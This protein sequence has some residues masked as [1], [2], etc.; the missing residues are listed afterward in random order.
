[1]SIIKNLKKKYGRFVID[2]P[3][4]NLPDQGITSLIGP[5]GAG[6]TSFL[7]ILS[8][9][10][11]CPSLQWIFNKQDLAQLPI[12]ERKIGFVFQ[13]LELFPHMTAYENIQFAGEISTKN[14]KKDLEFLTRSL[15]LT[16]I[17]H[18]KASELSRGEAQ[19]V[20]LSRALV[21]R[22]RILFLDEPF[23][24]LD[25]EN[26]KKASSIVQQMVEHYKIPALLI[27][28]HSEDIKNLSQKVIKIQNGKIQ[29]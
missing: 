17:I 25:D 9:L 16:P 24:S 5:S 14:W 7:R 8:G 19:R 2:I 20:A 18:Q 27:S 13:S 1:M 12:K 4:L 28:H 23:S 10:D 26:R 22:P 29:K 3:E 21:T 6:K 11:S 15:D